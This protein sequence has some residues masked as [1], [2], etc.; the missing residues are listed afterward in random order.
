MTSH[1]AL[2]L[3]IIVFF[4]VLLL[5]LAHA[6]RRTGLENGQAHFGFLN[7]LTRLGAETNSSL[8]V[9]LI[10]GTTLL[11][12]TT[13]LVMEV[14]MVD[15]F[16]GGDNG[17]ILGGVPLA[18][19]GAGILAV[20]AGSVTAV[21]T[22]R[23]NALQ[24][25]QGE[26]D[27]SRDERAW[28]I[29]MAEQTRHHHVQS[30]AWQALT[31]LA[32]PPGSK[33]GEVTSRLAL[34]A[35]R[36]YLTLDCLD[37]ECTA[38][39]FCTRHS[40]PEEVALEPAVRFAD[41]HATARHSPLVIAGSIVRSA[42]LARHHEGIPVLSLGSARLGD[43]R[44][45]TVTDEQ[46]RDRGGIALPCLGDPGQGDEE[47]PG[48][49]GTRAH[50]AE[51]TLVMNTPHLQLGAE[52]LRGKGTLHINPREGGV[53]DLEGLTIP[54]GYT[55]TIH[56]DDALGLEVR[57][58]GL[59]LKGTLKFLGSARTARVN[60][61]QV[62]DLG[63]TLDF[64]N[65]TFEQLSDVRVSVSPE[66]VEKDRE[67]PAVNIARLRLAASFF[68]VS[69]LNP[70]VLSTPA[71]AQGALHIS[72]VQCE[73]SYVSIKFPTNYNATKTTIELKDWHL[74]GARR[75]GS[76]H[77]E[78]ST[79][80]STPVD[81]RLVDTTAEGAVLSL[82]LSRCAGGDFD[83]RTQATGAT[84]GT[85]IVHFVRPSTPEGRWEHSVPADFIQ[86]EGLTAESPWRS[87]L[88]DNDLPETQEVGV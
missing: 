63:G 33:F 35:I 4:V 62:F 6:V 75:E 37:E 28:F 47:E 88:D 83:I 41:R 57:A 77:L 27:T 80:D 85:N 15:I 38:T 2:P 45:L 81:V 70:P 50:P 43:G 79:G 13:I 7:D 69:G 86:P 87:R 59:Y 1:S 74:E 5:G 52:A 22:Q 16:W 25:Q 82:D 8:V 17:T 65:A 30:V 49:D 14:K 51:I 56:M 67:S 18:H 21:H 78:A 71:G 44:H 58:S 66:F 76:L 84:P 23:A 73:R 11:A 61:E 12:A 34:G 36:R 48:Q 10:L 55:V 54:T 72:G 32:D 46:V 60:I 53:I 31:E 68:S 20:L 26:R 24:S 9:G 39:A 64:Y 40:W 19:I 42:N 29:Q 3:A